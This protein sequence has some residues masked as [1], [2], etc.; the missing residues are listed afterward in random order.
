MSD[1]SQWAFQRKID[2]FRRQFAQHASLPFS[3][4]LPA[5]MIVSATET[6]CLHCYQSIYNP[7]IALAW[8]LSIR[9]R[10]RISG[11]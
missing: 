8:A 2:W 1:C 6:L 3:D 5:Q 4:V 10:P 11:R 7:V 9:T